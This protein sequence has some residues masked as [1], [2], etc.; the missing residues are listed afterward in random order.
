MADFEGIEDPSILTARL[1][2][3]EGESSPRRQNLYLGD[4][5][6]EVRE[7]F[8]DIS[9]VGDRPFPCAVRADESLVPIAL[10]GPGYAFGLRWWERESPEGIAFVE[11]GFARKL[12]ETGLQAF[13]ASRLRSFREPI[14]WAAEWLGMQLP[15]FNGVGVPLGTAS[16][17]GFHVDVSASPN[18]R[19]HVSPTFRRN[20]RYFGSPTSPVHGVL[21]GGIYEFGADGGKYSSITADTAKFDIPYATVSPVL[22]L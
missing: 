13:L 15:I 5:Y 12:F 22:S 6:S 18:L 4:V 2:R 8:F 19:I 14:P 20:W 7:F 11:P 10:H 16:V 3:G 1:L 21:T 9:I 17:P